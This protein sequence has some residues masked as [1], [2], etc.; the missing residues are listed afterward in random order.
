VARD[1]Q[2]GSELTVTIAGA[3]GEVIAT[4]VAAVMSVGFVPITSDGDVVGTTRVHKAK[5]T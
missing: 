2:P 1:L 4:G 3:D 5:L